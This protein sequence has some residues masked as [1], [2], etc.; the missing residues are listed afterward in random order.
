MMDDL[1]L[2]AIIRSQIDIATGH[3]GGEIT[4]ERRQSLEYYY[5]EPYGNEL[6]G[7]SQVVTSEV[8]DVI[9]TIMPD[10]MQMFA[11]SDEMVRFEPHGEEDI[12]QAE[13][14]TAYVNYVFGRDNNGFE[15]LHD[16]IKDALLQINGFA[17]I[18]WDEQQVVTRHEMYDLDED[19]YMGLLSEEGVELVEHTE[20]L[21]DEVM[22]IA[23]QML[24]NLGDID[25][26]ELEP[27]L[28]KAGLKD[29]PK[30]HDVVI[31]RRR[32]KGK[33]KVVNVP[34]EEFLINRRAKDIDGSLFTAHKVSKT[35]TE[36]IQEGYDEDL[37]NSLPSHDELEYNQ[38]RVARFKR[39]DEWPYETDFTDASTRPVWVVECYMRV[40]YDED[41]EAELRKI[42]V[43][44][45]AYIILDNEEIDEIPF[46][47]ITPIRM[48]HKFFGRSVA[49]QVMD[50]QLIKS[51]VWRQ[52]LD[53][54]YQVNNSRFAISE[55]V[56]L[57]DY[58]SQRV[59]GA[60]RVRGSGAV[61]DAI[62]PMQTQPLGDY[63]YPLLEYID[64]V[65]E[66][67]TGI[68]RYS[69]GMDA[70]SLNKTYGGLSA[71]LNRSQQ[72]TLLI[73]RIFAE[74]GIREMMRKILRLSV[75]H[76]DKERMIRLQGEFVKFDPKTW[77]TSMDLV[78]QVGLGHGTEESKMAASGGIL[79]MQTQAIEMQGGA[80]GPLVDLHNVSN[81]FG[82][83]VR[84]LGF[85]NPDLYRQPIKK[86][87]QAPEPKG[88]DDAM[89]DL[90]KQQMQIEAETK[91]AELQLKQL[92][93]QTELKR[94]QQEMEMELQRKR[95]EMIAK[96]ALE[97]AEMKAQLELKRAELIGTAELQKLKTG[98]TI[99]DNRIKAQA[100]ADEHR[101][102]HGKE[103]KKPEKK[104]NGE[105]KNS[106]ALT[107]AIN[108]LS[109]VTK[110][111]GKP[112][113][114][115]RGKDGKISGTE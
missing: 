53:N 103:E 60:V 115:T 56:D 104:G 46:I 80:N 55:R 76:Q 97:E 71:I 74:T 45:D 96:L 85:K 8:Q 77:D 13:Q 75:K 19:E 82:D 106:A 59:G 88:E 91:K 15:I 41:G 69:Q 32:M 31:R 101:N 17:K 72:R 37:V 113:K 110:E 93:T 42:T 10:L 98:A 65:R 49:S 73:G 52:L 34:P 4:E 105:D 29:I 54:M 99:E 23:K 92:E 68:T 3:I 70:E 18:F 24:P 107:A 9:E 90:A 35:M 33:V 12:E 6:E 5:S 48:P 89:M 21:S 22:E 61:G 95:E 102:K 108:T 36:L 43:A 50:L 100:M 39:D 83:H 20:R 40:D 2:Q 57:D 84:S 63:A 67:R 26:E 111:M 1:T 30:T 78:V 64:T 47:S 86:G 14:A 38:E 7:R 62:Q 79:E 94:K 27:Q 16:L 28:V 112:K 51:T 114:V 58:L 25:P 11:A 109:A 66:L 44:G 87:F 81:A